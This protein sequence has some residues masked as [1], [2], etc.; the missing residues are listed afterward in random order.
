MANNITRKCTA[1][2]RYNALPYRYP[3]CKDLP[4]RRVQRTAPFEHVG[5]DYFGPLKVRNIN[6]EIESAY[7]CI[8]TCTTTRATHIELVNGLTTVQFINALRRFCARRGRPKTITC[9]N[10]PTFL[11]GEEILADCAKTNEDKTRE[12]CANYGIQWINITPYAPWQG[13][14]YERMVQLV[15]RCLYKAI[16]NRTLRSEELT[17]ILT[18]IEGILNTRPLT[19]V[20][21][22]MDDLRILRPVDL[23]QKDIDLQLP[24]KGLLENLED[25]V[26]APPE[27]RA[28]LRT[29]HDAETALA[30]SVNLVERFWRIWQKE[31]LP[32]LREHHQETIQSG[33]SS[34]KVPKQNDVVLM[35]DPMQPRHAWRMARVEHLTKDADGDVREI[36]LRMANGRT[37]KRP[38]NLVVPFELDETT[39]EPEP[40]PSADTVKTNEQLKPRSKYGLRPRKDR[41]YYPDDTTAASCEQATHASTCAK[42]PFKWWTFFM[43]I[44][45]LCAQ[46]TIALN[47]TITCVENT[48]IFEHLPYDEIEICAN[49]NCWKGLRSDLERKKELQLRARHH[50]L[51]SSAICPHISCYLCTMMV[52]NP[53]CWPVTSI[54]IAGLIIYGLGLGMIALCFSPII[55]GTP[56]LWCWR[57]LRRLVRNGW[58]RICRRHTSS[59]PSVRFRRSTIRYAFVALVAIVAIGQIPGVTACQEV[60]IL[61]LENTVCHES[62]N[63]KKCSVKLSQIVKINPFHRRACINFVANGTRKAEL[64]LKWKHVTLKCKPRTLTFTRNTGRELVSSKRCWQAGSC[65]ENV[66]AEIRPDNNTLP[67]LKKGNPHPGITS[68][69]E[70]CGWWGCDCALAR[71]GCAFFRLFFPPVND[72]IYKHFDCPMWEEELV[73]D[74]EIVYVD[75]PGANR[76]TL[77]LKPNIPQ[78]TSTFK[79]TVTLLEPVYISMLHDSFLATENEVI[80]ETEAHVQL[81]DKGIRHDRWNYNITDMMADVTKRLPLSMYNMKLEQ[82]REDTSKIQAIVKNAVESE[83]I[84]DFHHNIT[85]QN[86]R[87]ISD[88]CSME[89]QSLQG[90]Y[91][92]KEGAIGNAT[93]TTQHY[94]LTAIVMCEDAAFAIPCHTSGAEMSLRFHYES[95][96]I[97]ELCQVFCGGAAN[98]FSV[99]GTLNYVGMVSMKLERPKSHVEEY[100]TFWPDFSHLG[101]IFTSWYKTTLFTVVAALGGVFL[102]YTICTTCGPKIFLFMIKLIWKLVIVWPFK[103]LRFIMIDRGL[104][105]STNKRKETH[106]P[107]CTHSCDER[108]KCSDPKGRRSSQHLQPIV[109]RELRS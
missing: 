88:Q 72:K 62:Y 61:S 101:S 44:L 65:V 32:G 54:L 51:P 79:A 19:Y 5:L 92:C 99:Q 36:E 109:K 106:G 58:N 66:C 15:K 23:L 108:N 67:E 103:I 82:N 87:V 38:V 86:S 34:N 7:G 45:A 14:F 6:E 31:Y 13:G 80:K 24:L 21:S 26:Y 4:S 27:E 30:S 83:L 70:S 37:V 46:P 17:T 1:C 78:R 22:E 39:A 41:N 100:K 52:A 33:R 95:A 74:W 53:E 10:A 77:K 81:R 57:Q 60:D 47:N 98:T 73:L 16:G 104:S 102:T 48:V 40:I 89:M 69:A 91:D 43:L 49:R 42:T 84:L 59:E 12:F 50:S 105:L 25:P 18:E 11:L 2:Q 55:L 20:G 35:N 63:D 71:S 9:D 107:H 8:F 28:K 90:C 68:C 97:D 3:N 75:D 85:V 93:C 96:D 64:T 94:N 29:R 56:F 76:G